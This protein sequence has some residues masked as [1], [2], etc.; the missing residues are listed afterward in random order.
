MKILAS[1]FGGLRARLGLDEEWLSLAPGSSAE[2]AARL[3]CARLGPEWLAALRLA[4]NDE[5]V[6]GRTPL[7][8]GDRLALLPPVSGGRV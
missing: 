7:H 4:V 3:A 6:P 1:Y 5:F 8:D 2:E